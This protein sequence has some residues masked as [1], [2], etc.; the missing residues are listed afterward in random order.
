[1]NC[2][3]CI[4]S[5][6]QRRQQFKQSIASKDHPDNC[7]AGSFLFSLQKK[8]EKESSLKDKFASVWKYGAIRY[9]HHLVT[10]ICAA[11]LKIIIIK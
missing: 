4:F 10:F 1:M 9:E 5:K 6:E 8:I 7:I 2:N 3:T 11:I